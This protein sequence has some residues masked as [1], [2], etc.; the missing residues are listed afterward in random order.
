MLKLFLR[1]YLLLMLPAT[2]AFVGCMYLTDQ[3]MAQVHADTQRSRAGA[4]FDRAERIIGATDVPDREE[5]LK[6]IE[7]TFRIEHRILPTA[8]VADDWFMSRPE[9]ERLA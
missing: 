2:A 4:A 7:A 8:Q 6:E 3:V 9:K 1:L 5:R